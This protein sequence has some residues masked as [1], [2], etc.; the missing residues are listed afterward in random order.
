MDDAGKLYDELVD[1]TK[2]QR[3]QLDSVQ[4]EVQA[5]ARRDPD[6]WTAQRCV[7]EIRGTDPD[8]DVARQRAAM[9]LAV[10]AIERDADEP[11][12]LAQSNLDEVRNSLVRT[13]GDF[14]QEQINTRTRDRV[15]RRL[16]TAKDHGSRA[17][18]ARIALEQAADRAELGVLLQELP[19]ELQSLGLDEDTV[20]R[21]IDPVVRQR[22]PEL[23]AAQDMLAEKQFEA[24]VTHATAGVV[25]RGLDSGVPADKGVLGMLDPAKIRARRDVGKIQ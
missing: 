24:T 20:R 3:Q 7:A 5:K 17:N 22:V 10:E 13:K 8:S 18:I 19:S 23:A 15:L 25:R 16:Q 4:A 2:M 1:L 12:T 21:V 11:V 9:K 6:L 14:S